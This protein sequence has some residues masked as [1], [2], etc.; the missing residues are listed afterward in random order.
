MK[1][2]FCIIDAKNSKTRRWD[3]VPAKPQDMRTIKSKALGVCSHQG[4][5]TKGGNDETIQRVPSG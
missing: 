2:S 5:A 4:L 1:I 3:A